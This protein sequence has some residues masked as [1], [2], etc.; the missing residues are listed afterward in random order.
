[1]GTTTIRRSVTYGRLEQLLTAL[2]L[3]GRTVGDRCRVYRHA[4]SDTVVLLPAESA[5]TPA[6]SADLLSVRRHLVDAGHLDE[7]ALDEFLAT[8]SLPSAR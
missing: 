6:R 2:G 3:K 4:A 1:M 5:D 8:G 7:Q